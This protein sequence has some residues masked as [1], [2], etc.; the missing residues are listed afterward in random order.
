[1]DCHMPRINEGLQDM[2]RTHRIFKPS[3]RTMIEANQP[4]ACNLCHLDKSIEWTI[5]HLSEWYENTPDYSEA[6]L[7]RSY[8]K[9][10]G[11]VGLGW[12]A[13][14]HEPTRLASA[15]ALLRSEAHWALPQLLEMLDDPYMINRQF[16]QRGLEMM[17]NIR[18]ED[19][20]YRFY[21]TPEERAA[22]IGRLKAQL[23]ERGKTGGK[24]DESR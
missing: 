19:H 13:T 3:E 16:T 10:K 18:L 11:P 4:N 1:M 9:R 15:S 5:G 8:P 21:M 2:V 6:A 12:L 24:P 22:P 23:L 17:L 14:E 7:A 20:G